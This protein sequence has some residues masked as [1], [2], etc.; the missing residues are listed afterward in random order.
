MSPVSLLAAAE[1]AATHPSIGTP[2]L[3]AITIGAIAVLFVVD[4]L[5]TR[6]PH[7]VS[8]KE[9]IGWSAFYVAIPLGFGVWIW[10]QYGGDRGL[11]YY[12]GYLVEKSLSVDNLFVFLLLLTA[13]AV[14]REL[15]QRVLLIGVA[16]ALVLRGVF[17]ALG[18]QLISSFSWAFLL[19]GAVLLVT[20]VKVGRDALS[21]KEHTVDIGSLRTVRL[22]SR[23]W[24]VT[25]SYDGTRMTVRQAGRRALTPLALVTVAILGTDV[26][27]AIDSVPAV[28][29]ITGDA[30]LVFATNAFALLGLRALYFVVEGALGSLRHLGHGLAAIL[31]F[32]GVKLV[33][34]WAHGVWPGVPEVPTLASL[35]V[36]VGILALATTTSILANRRDRRRE[37][38]QAA[39]ADP[40]AL[41]EVE[42][43]PVDS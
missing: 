3:W 5:I 18:A 15:Q 27:F 23:L 42:K 14:P 8:M 38:E 35:A 9:A 36:I 17:I 4:F 37:L 12:T 24:P 33:L 34:H 10:Q 43:E 6:R 31:A 22:L 19:F 29:G 26:V 21:D 41:R 11:E 13:F 25:E 20:A 40:V 1:P 30:Y 32:I 16:G 39:Q 28:Y 2:A 7:E